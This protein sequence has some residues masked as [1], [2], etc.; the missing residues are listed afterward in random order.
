MGRLHHAQSPSRETNAH[1]GDG[2]E[3]E[4]RFFIADPSV[5]PPLGKGVKMVQCYLPRWKIQIIDSNL[6]LEERVLVRNLSMQVNQSLSA[7]IETADIT[8]RIRLVE[9][10]AFV[11]VK[12]PVVDYAR[13]EWEFEVMV[14]DVRDLVTSFRFPHVLKTRFEV[15]TEDGLAW[16]WLGGLVMVC[17][18]IACGAGACARP[19]AHSYTWTRGVRDGGRGLAAAPP[20]PFEH[21]HGVRACPRRSSMRPTAFEHADGVR[22]CPRRSSFFTAF[23]SSSRRSSLLHGARVILINE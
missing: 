14:E 20:P 1:V 15:P 23:E 5:L 12:G 4:Y 8:P 21:A 10:S 16:V 7:L 3:I 19:D 22:A 18:S 11:T 6:C 13:A 9:D 17:W 2:V